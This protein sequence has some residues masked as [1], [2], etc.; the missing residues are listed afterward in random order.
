MQ[1]RPVLIG[2]ALL[3]ALFADL[4][5]LRIAQTEHRSQIPTKGHQVGHV[6]TSAVSWTPTVFFCIA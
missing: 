1:L 6:R 4:L 2:A 3:I 5:A